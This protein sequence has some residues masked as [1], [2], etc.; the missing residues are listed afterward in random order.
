[1]RG[2][3]V[4]VPDITEIDNGVLCYTEKGACMVLSNGSEPISVR[5]LRQVRPHS[6]SRA[7]IGRYLRPDLIEYL[8]R[9]EKHWGVKP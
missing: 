7:T 8:K 1:M 6:S 2:A 9:K 5:R 4:A 3:V